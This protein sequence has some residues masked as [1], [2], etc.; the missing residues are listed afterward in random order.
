MAHL[1][2]AATP[3]TQGILVF[4]HKERDRFFKSHSLPMGGLDNYLCGT[5]YGG[6]QPSIR[7]RRPNEQF[8]MGTETAVRFLAPEPYRIPYLARNFTPSFFAPN[9][10]VPK[11]YDVLC[12]SRCH[13]VKNLNKLCTAMRQLF[14]A[15]KRLRV[16]LIVPGQKKPDTKYWDVFG[17][18]KK[19]FSPAERK[20]FTVVHAPGTS[21][22][23]MPQEKLVEYYQR[24]RAFVLPSQR[25]GSP[26]VVSE[27]LLCGCTVVLDEKLKGGGLDQINDENAVLFRRGYSLADALV[28]AVA[29]SK[30]STWDSSALAQEI[31]EDY[32][33][34]KLKESF[35]G[36]YR[37]HDQEFDGELLNTDN[38]NFRLNGH[39]HD[40]PWFDGNTKL[41][42]D[43]VTRSQ[44]DTFMTY[45][46][47][48]E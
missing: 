46:K 32:T 48:H 6:V 8:I 35:R 25:E 2:K 23:G 39:W 16:H 3:T 18:H 44:F 33:L 19:K 36:L 28:D 31:R 14:D 22:R 30:A 45:V 43:I 9:P 26:K 13:K 27:A 41:P 5:H 40:V 47:D 42:A 10:E 11:R 12:V 7:K 1:F 38:L 20:I 4:T 24:A 34:D 37:K 21:F 17:H 29:K 15:G